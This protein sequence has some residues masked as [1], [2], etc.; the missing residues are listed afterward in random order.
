VCRVCKYQQRLE[1][2]IGFPGAGVMSN[3]GSG[4]QTLALYKNRKFS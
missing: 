4:K 2:G 1:E 3:M